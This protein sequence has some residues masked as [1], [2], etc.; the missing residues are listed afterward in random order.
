MRL[1]GTRSSSNVQ[2]ARG[3]RGKVALSGGAIVVVIV[4]S[5]LTGINPLTLLGQMQGPPSSS[6]SSA[7]PP[8]DDES[9]TFVSQVLATTEDTW[10]RLL[11]GYREPKLV[12]FRE[13]VDSA[14]GFATAA[15]GPFYCPLDE[16]AYLDLT[17]FDDLARRFGAPGDFAAAY[18]IAHEIGH[19]VQKLD[20][21]GA[22]VH[23]SRDNQGATSQAV[24]LELQADCY[25]G[26]WAFDANKRGLL[27]VGDV[28]E[29][30]KAAHQIGDDTLQ[31][32]GR[33]RVTPDSFTH[34]TAVQR[35]RWFKTGLASG[36][37]RRCDTFS[38][39][40]L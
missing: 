5:A 37:P 15:V 21:T 39:A 40:S 27:E 23:A 17:F 26:V 4:I 2:D 24:R 19:H 16:K 3:S 28:D 20:G 13:S 36:D 29:A 9:A 18:V 34:G 33:G 31:K 30:L 22:R 11:P 14:C 38:A 32:R 10:H 1:G 12:L 35:S 7:P 8:A 6:S 25:A